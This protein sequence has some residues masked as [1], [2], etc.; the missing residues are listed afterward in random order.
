MTSGRLTGCGAR[1]QAHPARF[2][3]PLEITSSVAGDNG[4][5][6]GPGRRRTWET[7]QWSQFTEI[8]A[9][10]RRVHRFFGLVRTRAD[11]LDLT[12]VHRVDEIADAVD[13][14]QNL[15]RLEVQP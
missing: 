8:I 4:G 7:E 9:W 5:G 1:R 11:Q 3:K 14:E 10:P 2:G 15:A 13:R 6:A 12:L